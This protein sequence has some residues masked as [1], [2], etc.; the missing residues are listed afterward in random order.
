[1]HCSRLPLEK[2]DMRRHRWDV[3]LTS[4]TVC[5]VVILNR[6]WSDKFVVVMDWT[7]R[8]N[9]KEI[10]WQ[11]MIMIGFAQLICKFPYLLCRLVNHPERIQQKYDIWRHDALPWFLW[12]CLS[13]FTTPYTTSK[14]HIW[15]C[16]FD[17]KQS[18][19]GHLCLESK[20][21]CILFEMDIPY[22]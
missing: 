13:P 2:N 21:F 5:C 18:C 15:S 8:E 7:R 3:C 19:S 17:R 11:M 6:I 12:R 1:M 14:H 4:E 22:S 16:L 9:K 10:K 20:T